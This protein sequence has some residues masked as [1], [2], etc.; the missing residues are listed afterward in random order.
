MQCVGLTSP[1]MKF[2]PTTVRN[3]LNIWAGSA[4]ATCNAYATASWC[5][6][7]A[8]FV[9]SVKRCVVAVM[10]YLCSCARRPRQQQATNNP[11]TPANQCSRFY[12]LFLYKSV[13]CHGSHPFSCFVLWEAVGSI[14][15]KSGYIPSRL[16]VSS[17]C[18]CSAWD[19][20]PTALRSESFTP[21]SLH[22]SNV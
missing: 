18:H 14:W 13:T 22:M 6:S 7:V 11:T 1:S 5:S 20:M 3:E 16:C 9:N 12:F 8:I 2:G 10:F 17:M 19:A 21:G 15:C 4:P